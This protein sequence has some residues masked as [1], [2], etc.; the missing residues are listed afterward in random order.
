MRNTLI[1]LVLSLIAVLPACLPLFHSGFFTFHDNEQV[2]RLYDLNKDI[3]NLNFPPRLT[4]DLG[5]GFDYPLFNFYPPL[6]YYIAE[7]FK[8][9]GFSYI[10]SIKIT[11]GL[12]FYLSFIFMYLF[13]K[14][15]F[16]KIA[17]F[18][19]ALSYTYL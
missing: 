6:V 13:A 8:L 19:A 15:H 17:A 14:E 2:A 11:I 7:I 10:T 9:T 12:G 1:L 16:G 18:L 3:V 4:Q 5:Y